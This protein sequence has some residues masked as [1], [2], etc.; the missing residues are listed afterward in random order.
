MV[1]INGIEED[2][3]GM[4]L[5]D[6]LEAKQYPAEGIA[7]ECNEE[8]LAKSQYGSYLLQD[9]DVIEIVSFV[10]GG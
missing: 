9:G 5:K 4:A 10:G 2:A 7:V 1:R 8:I 3:A 6:Y